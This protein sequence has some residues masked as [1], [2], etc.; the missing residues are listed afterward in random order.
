MKIVV[1]IAR[2]LLGLI[3]F[4]F[5]LNFFLHFIPSPLPPGDAGVL[6]GMMFKHGWFYFIG[7]LYVVGGLLLLIGRYVP[8]GLV[9]LGPIIVII[10]LFHITFDLKTIGM[11]LFVAALEVFLIWAYRS[12]FRALFSSKLELS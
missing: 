5:G 9:L 11:G 12:H 3:F 8:I 4:V 10:L 1:L 2:I 7:L 6:I